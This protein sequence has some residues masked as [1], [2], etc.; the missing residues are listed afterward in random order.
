MPVTRRSGSL[1]VALL[2][3]A[4]ACGGAEGGRSGVPAPSSGVRSGAD[5]A[6]VRSSGSLDL[7]DER[8]DI[9][10]PDVR[11]TT[12]DGDRAPL[13]TDPREVTVI[14]FWATWCV[15]C[16]EEIP[17]L[18]TLEDSIAP[19]GG[20]V[21]GIAVS[22]GDPADIEAFARR[23]DMDY[24]LGAATSEWTRRHFTIFG[25]PVTLVVDRTGVIRRRLVGPH[26]LAGFLAAARPYLRTPEGRERE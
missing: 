11:V 12:L 22:S 3:G 14:N 7:P 26:R 10:L 4:A 15:P 2:L 5:A 21:L 6:A 24:D 25:L 9:R 19:R 1:L 13:R 16:L 8:L 20:R 17:E 23:H 18:V